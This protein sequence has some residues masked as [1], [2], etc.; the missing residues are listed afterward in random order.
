L[1]EALPVLYLI[2]G[3]NLIHALGL[4]PRRR[5]PHLLEKARSGLLGLLHGSLG[6]QAAAITVVFDAAQAPPGLPAEQDHHGIHVVFAVHEA[7]ADDLIE[8]L[9]RQATPGQLTV[10][11]DDHRIQ[12]AARRRS[13]VVLECGEYLDWLAAQ[14]RPRSARP[15]QKEWQ[16]PEGVSGA[17]TRRWLEV[18][19]DLEND[20]AFRELKDLF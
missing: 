13:C 19:G 10:V 6:E 14:R 8:Q 12:Q 16:K 1:G 11:S 17:E 15:A 2:D 9:I 5:A 18:F 20:P 4:L 3:Y 7:Q